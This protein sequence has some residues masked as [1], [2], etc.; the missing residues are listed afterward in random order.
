MPIH[1]PLLQSDNNLDIVQA[2]P[3]QL[4]LIVHY[5]CLIPIVYAVR[6]QLDFSRYFE[7]RTHCVRNWLPSFVAVVTNKQ[8]LVL[9]LDIQEALVSRFRVLLS[10]ELCL[11]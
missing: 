4:K 2:L 3:A 6:T 10:T 1:F 9:K 11:L 7:F 8:F 5:H